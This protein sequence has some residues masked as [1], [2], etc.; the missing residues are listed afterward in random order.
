MILPE[1]T[2]LPNRTGALK[3][4]ILYMLYRKP[5]ASSTPMHSRSAAP[6][7]DQVQT[8]TNEFLRRIRNT[9][10]KLE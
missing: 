1:G 3:Q 4:I 9:S 5:V 8:A 6:S 7:K 2:T 10:R